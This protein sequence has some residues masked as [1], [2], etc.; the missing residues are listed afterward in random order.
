MSLGFYQIYTLLYSVQMTIYLLSWMVRT[1]WRR[2]LVLPAWH[3]EVSPNSNLT[4]RK[5]ILLL[6][7]K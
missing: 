1:S 5:P 6:R 4:Q 7:A 3:R 2:T